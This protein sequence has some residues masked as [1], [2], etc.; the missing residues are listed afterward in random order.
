VLL[1]CA[2]CSGGDSTT[3]TPPGCGMVPESKVVGLL[4]NDVDATL[5]GS[6][7]GLRGGKHVTAS[8]RTVSSDEK[9]YVD[10]VATYHPKPYPLPKDACDEGWV[11]AGTPDKYTP[12]CQQYAGGKGT[13]ELIVRWQPYVMRVTIGRPDRD[14]GGDPERALA[15]T[16]ALAQDLGVEEAAGDG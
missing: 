1:T 14:W 9:R 16:R 2:A 4:G 15:M 6:V 7:P 12:A 5:T 11:Y 8:C 3:V 13:T 10:V